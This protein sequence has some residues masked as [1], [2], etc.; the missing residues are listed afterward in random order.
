VRKSSRL[1]RFWLRRSLRFWLTA[2]MVLAIS[3]LSVSALAGYILYRDHVVQPLVE[4]AMRQRS[5]LQPLQ[6][7]QLDLWSLSESIN[8]Y[9]VDGQ[10]RHEDEYHAEVEAIGADLLA[11]ARAAGDNAEEAVI[12]R[13]A[14]ADWNLVAEQA[15]AV[16]AQG[17]VVAD[18]SLRL[19]V[20][21]FEKDLGVLAQDIETFHALLRQ[22]SDDALNE[23]LTNLERSEE[24]ALI[25]FVLS[26]IFVFLGVVVINRSLVTSMN[27]LTAAA[28]R[29]AAGDRSQHIQIQ[30]PAELVNVATA[31]NAMTDQIHEQER[32]LAHLAQTDGLTGL[33]NRREFDRMLAEEVRR[34]ERF[35]TPVSLIMI[36]IDNFKAFNDDHGH[37][38]GDEA[39]RIVAE[40]LQRCVRGTDKA[41]RFGGEELAVIMTASDPASSQRLA[42]RIREAVAG[43]SI[44]LSSD[45]SAQATAHVTVSLGVATAPDCAQGSEEL[46]RAADDALYLSKKNGRNRVAAAPPKAP[47]TIA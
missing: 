43:Q 40:T 21:A 33:F 16:L 41:F 36:D 5:L 13:Q 9:V 1:A 27:Q 22:D 35:G 2:G 45:T 20:A 47:Q 34:S 26:L 10:A 39:L 6:D 17:G 11:L 29:L 12:L 32:A 24:I 37:Q 38:G 15:A 3:P 46:L 31:F 28:A 23:A 44:P 7:L 14:H 8:D 4:D 42:E 19:P 30:I 18:E 25:A